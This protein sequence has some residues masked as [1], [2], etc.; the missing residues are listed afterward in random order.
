MKILVEL[1]SHKAFDF[2]SIDFEK[3]L[4][5][6][7]KI[8]NLDGITLLIETL[9]LNQH[10]F[11]LK[12]INIIKFLLEVNRYNNCS[13]DRESIM[14]LLVKT[15]VYRSS[16]VI[17]DHFDTSLIKNCNCP[18]LNLILNKVIEMD[19]LILVKRLIESQELIMNIN[20]KDINGKLPIIVAYYYSTTFNFT[21]RN[22]NAM[23]IFEYLLD[24]GANC[25][26]KGNNHSLLS[27][28]IHFK[29]YM[30]TRCL[31]KHNVHIDEDFSKNYHPLLKAIYQNKI[32][33]IKLL[34]ENRNK[35]K[36]D[37]NTTHVPIKTNKYG[38]T[39]LIL[40]YLLNHR[41]IFKYL[42][43]YEDVNEFDSNGYT[44]LHYAI[45]KEDIETIKY[46]IS[47]G[48]DINYKENTWK[49]YNSAL[50]IS[51]YIR[52]KE[53]FF[54][55]LYSKNIEL[56]L[57]N[58]KGEIPLVVTIKI[59]NYPIDYKK[60]IIEN[61]VKRGSDIN[62]IDSRKNT[63]LVYAI[64]EKCFPVVELLVENGA[65]INYIITNENYWESES[66]LMFAIKQGEEDITK[67][68]IECRAS[69]NFKNKYEIS[70]FLET[71]GRNRKIEIFEY[72][73][74]WDR[75][76]FSSNI[77]KE[78]I[79]KKRLDLLKI[80]VSHHLDIDLKDDHGN[81]PLIYAIE[82]KDCQI[83]DYLFKCGAGI[84]GIN[85]KMEIIRDIIND[86]RLDLLKILVNHHLDIFQKD[87]NGLTFLSYAFY[88]SQPAIV[89]YLIHC[90]ADIQ[91]IVKDVKIVITIIY[92]RSL[93][94][95]KILMANHLNVNIKDENGNTPLVYA[96]KALD[97]QIVDYLIECGA[98]IHNVNHEGETIYDISYQYSN[99]YWGRNIYTKI[100]K[101]LNI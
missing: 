85:H 14:K 43:K 61:L 41:K 15:L 44:I 97:E 35:Y 39:P 8:S 71:V 51:I 21:E 4:F 32:K 73:A 87:E 79:V 13:H 62:F 24:H 99:F 67:Y 63:P 38:F 2:K 90:G 18:S 52:N 91:S 69:L 92:N 6:A 98:D 17:D 28:A 7:N 9:L 88:S 72:L 82:A 33:T 60:F 66:T 46:L 77:I 50:D 34:I 3:I 81:T 19:N 70:D 27:S 36:N 78:I 86:G 47:I 96:I 26:V 74:Q 40:S 93:E 37:R 94:L 22:E 59:K 58:G 65:N 95:L 5:N 23:E 75:N 31:L 53:I 16:K 11:D 45:L 12:N 10:S 80:L 76:I 57:P 29:H 30:V 54:I 56:N 84:Y 20:V 83:V 64:Q 25:N 68:L 101:L 55:L 1:L 42:I 89:S 49:S 48:S 100:K